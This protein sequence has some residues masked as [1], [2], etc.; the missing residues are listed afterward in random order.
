[1]Y[2][3]VVGTLFP[4]DDRWQAEE[5]QKR[6]TPDAQV[7]TNFESDLS[8]KPCLHEVFPDNT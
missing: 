2:L 6:T 4:D 1:M 5:V 3:M 8:N 7:P